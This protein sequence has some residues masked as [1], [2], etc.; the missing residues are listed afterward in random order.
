MRRS[1]A[2]REA[3]RCFRGGGLIAYPTEAVFGLGCDP[4]DGTA[5]E[6][7]L[8][9]KRRPIEKGLILIAADFGQLE[10]YLGPLPKQRMDEILGTWPG[11][12]TWL[13]PAAPDCP[14]WVTGRHRTLAVRVTA[15][16]LAR[17]LCLTCASPLVSTSANL[18]GR[19]PARTVLAV[20]LQFGDNV[21]YLLHGRLGDRKR[22][23]P[24]RDGRTGAVVRA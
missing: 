9:L 11:P 6:R 13:L 5:V 21:D 16:S 22:P 7:L 12:A 10:P 24:I 1:W 2:L 14:F 23:T 19:P 4:R 20:R 18:S 17:E 3:T 8:V 15:H